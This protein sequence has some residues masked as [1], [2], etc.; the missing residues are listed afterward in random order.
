MQPK[1]SLLS[2]LNYRRAHNSTTEALF[3][4]EYLLPIINAM[5]HSPAMDYEGNIWVKTEEKELAPYLFCAHIDTCHNTEGMQTPLVKADGMV[6]VHPAD[7]AGGCLGADDGVGI[8]ASLR[9]MKA[10]VKGT[11][12]FTR[13]EERGGIGASYIAHHTP[14]KLEG[15]KMCI[16]VDRA[17][18][19]EVIISQSYG[20]CASVEFGQ[21][22]SDMLGMG[23]SPSTEGVYT[24]NAEFGDIIPESVNIAA[25]YCHQHTNRETVNTIYVEALIN[26]L[27][28]IDWSELA[29]VREPGDY[30]DWMGCGGNYSGWGG[31]MSSQDSK[32]EM[33][34]EYI[35]QHPCRVANYLEAIGVERYE[36][37]KE[38]AYDQDEEEEK[39]AS[40]M[41]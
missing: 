20:D 39:L 35:T 25:G 24:D 36:I 1:L 41:Y 37:E 16:Q 18:T 38:W 31:H 15:F 30:G 29:I 21:Q 14:Y 11:Y 26:K 19:A 10:G 7:F 4:N 32:Y 23:H 2:I 27:I 28:D 34:L 3:I 40:G 9:M 17:D 6:A 22:L 8:Y 33:L 5:G 13:G 12:L